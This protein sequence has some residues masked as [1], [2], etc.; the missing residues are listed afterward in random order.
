RSAAVR[1]RISAAWACFSSELSR[2][3][4]SEEHTSEL[5]SPMYLVCRLLLEKT[6]NS[7]RQIKRRASVITVV[8]LTAFHLDDASRFPANFFFKFGGDSAHNHLS[9]TDHFP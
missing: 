7:P 6:R 8:A 9:Q 3:S 4:R 2:I 1:R 5:Q